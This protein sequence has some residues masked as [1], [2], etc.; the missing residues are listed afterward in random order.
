MCIRD[1]VNYV[2]FDNASPDPL[3]NNAFLEAALERARI[4]KS[5]P[6]VASK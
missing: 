5:E 2:S 1:R 3:E 6:A 4:R